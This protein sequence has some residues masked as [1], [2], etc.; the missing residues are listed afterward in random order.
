VRLATW[1]PFGA[2]YVLG[3]RAGRKRYEDLRKFAERL[4]G[5]FDD[6]GVRRRLQTV[7]TRLEEYARE[8]SA[9]HTS[10]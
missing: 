1:S 4:A 3:S 5:E 9:P 10:T 2:G 6:V 7:S 8:H